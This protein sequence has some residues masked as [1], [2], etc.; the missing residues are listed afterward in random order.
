[1]NVPFRPRLVMFLISALQVSCNT[2][3]D[4]SVPH[5]EI[6]LARV[7][8]LGHSNLLDSVSPFQF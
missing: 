2:T 1:M 6:V 4:D 8:A 3:M 7:S 5:L